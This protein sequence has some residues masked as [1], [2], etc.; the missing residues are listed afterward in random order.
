MSTYL[1]I[2]GAGFIGSHVV[3]QLLARGERVR[4]LDEVS[5][6]SRE[7]LARALGRKRGAP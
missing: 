5:S 1:V 7:N 3:E 6:G 2:G 4:V